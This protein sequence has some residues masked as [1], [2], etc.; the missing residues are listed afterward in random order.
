MHAAAGALSVLAPPVTAQ[1]ASVGSAMESHA[2][3]ASLAAQLAEQALQRY[4]DALAA[5]MVAQCA[6]CAYGRTRQRGHCGRCTHERR[7]AC[8]AKWPTVR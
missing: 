7:S 8:Q 3:F 4:A 6:P 5:E 2:A 1:H